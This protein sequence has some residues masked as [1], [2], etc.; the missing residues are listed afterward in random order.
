MDG[1]ENGIATSTFPGWDTLRERRRLRMPFVLR[2]A[3]SYFMDGLPGPSDVEYI[4]DKKLASGE[5]FM[6]ISRDGQLAY[7]TRA[8]QP[9]PQKSEI[10]DLY[11]QGYT[12]ICNYIAKDLP[13]LFRAR[14]ML[15]D[16]FGEEVECSTF[17]TP[18]SCQGFSP[19]F[20]AAD[21]FVIQTHGGKHWR[22][23]PAILTDPL[24]KQKASVPRDHLSDPI[25]A[26]TLT[27]GDVL[28]IPRGIIHEGVAAAKEDA[29]AASVH[30]SFG[31]L[32]NKVLDALKI[33]LDQLATSHPWLR[34]DLPENLDLVAALSQLSECINTE[35]MHRYCEKVIRDQVFADRLERHPAVS[36]N[37]FSASPHIADRSVPLRINPHAAVRFSEIDPAQLIFS[38]GSG[39]QTLNLPIPA[40]PLVKEMLS[41]TSTFTLSY[42]PGNDTPGDLDMLTAEQLLR[43]D[44]IQV[45]DAN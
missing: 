31:L 14:T 2:G 41:A 33:Y 9:S 38:V 23:Y 4:L 16:V 39:A 42:L 37:V 26:T 7:P 3:S 5:Q 11:R 21:L 25:L 18:H 30:I 45:C 40:V 28:Y 22:L 43:L 6:Q 13:S 12:V 34:E 27:P 10:L 19:H 20:D 8:R 35:S 32:T 44:I 36:G 29:G 17:M 15:Q 24:E 1:D